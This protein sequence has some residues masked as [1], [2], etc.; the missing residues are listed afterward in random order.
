M[1]KLD[2]FTQER[3][4]F[5]TT[6][7]DFFDE[8]ANC[9]MWLEYY[10]LIWGLDFLIFTWNAICS[11][12]FEQC[13]CQSSLVARSR[14][15]ASRVWKFSRVF[16]AGNAT[17]MMI[18]VTHRKFTAKFMPLVNHDGKYHLRSDNFAPL[19]HFWRFIFWLRFLM[20]NG[21]HFDPKIVYWQK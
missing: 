1:S 17:R 16:G 15:I 4:Q 5:S 8:G 20:T 3:K 6:Y 12:W 14:K 2:I 18:T 19:K 13:H 7:W 11:R 10:A 9:T 21:S